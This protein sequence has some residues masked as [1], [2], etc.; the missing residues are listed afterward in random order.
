MTFGTPDD[1]MPGRQSLQQ[2]VAAGSRQSSGSSSS[3]P[4]T[5]TSNGKCRSRVTRFNTADAADDMLRTPTNVSGHLAPAVLVSSVLAS[6]A[7]RA[8]GKRVETTV[9]AMRMREPAA[10][11]CGGAALLLLVAL[12]ACAHADTRF[13]RPEVIRF[14]AG[15]AE[16]ERAL[17]GHCTRRRLWTDAPVF[18]PGVRKQQS[19]IDC[20]G[21]QFFGQG[22]RLELVF[23]DGRLV[24]VW[25]MVTDAEAAAMIDSMARAYGAP[26]ERNA[27]YVTFARD[28]A[29]WRYRPAEIL[30]WSEELDADV[31]CVYPVLSRR[32]AR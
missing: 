9:V 15:V 26:T 13:E 24:L 19:Q 12:G 6:H 21:F 8:R 32:C 11:T 29:A 3:D 25:L 14:G 16:I 22:R 5:G 7:G 30:F 23:R 27:D 10:R 31:A 18:L 4:H 28:R 1:R 17:E 2:S 20:D